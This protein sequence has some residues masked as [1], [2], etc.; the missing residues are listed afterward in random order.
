MTLS[1]NNLLFVRILVGFSKLTEQMYSPQV[2]AMAKTTNLNV[3]GNFFIDLM[4]MESWNERVTACHT[5]AN[6]VH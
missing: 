1:S 4:S 6:I 5:L 2:A 3:D